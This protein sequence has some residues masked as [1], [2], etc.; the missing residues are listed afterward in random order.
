[1]A[2]VVDG[3]EWCFD[4]WPV[5]DICD[6]MNLLLERVQT[7]RDRNETVWIGDELQT[8]PVLGA[9]DL[10][11]LYSPTAPVSLPPEIWQELTAWLG[12]A[13]RYGDEPNWPAG[14]EETLIQVDADP[15]LGNADL[16]WAHHNVRAG[17]AVACIGLTRSGPHH[18][19]SSLGS[20]T[21]HWVMSEA[22]NRAFWRAAI[23]LEGGNEAT[24]QRLASHAFPDLH[25][26][27]ELWRGLNHLA[28]GYFAMRD[29]IRKYLTALDDF[30][31]WVFTSPPPALSPQDVVASEPGTDPSN[32]IIERRFL[33]LNLDMAPENPNVYADNKCRKAREITV[34]TRTLYCEWHG[35]LEPHRNRIHV[36]PPT[37]E[38]EGKVII[39][40][41]H[42]HLRLP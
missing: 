24:L 6:A 1:M 32:Q 5:D 33:G 25:F 34:R 21:V 38:S 29:Q 13:P 7:A 16:A 17:H 28:G 26:H 39:A 27:D 22:T 42:E 30:G 15:A 19:V 23:D 9:L 31:C 41:F 10:W 12:A 11:S 37:A 3:A 20:A 18:T 8:R 36:H 35:K 2:F 40:I 14:I 4:H